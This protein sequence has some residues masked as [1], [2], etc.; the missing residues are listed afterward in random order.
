M[1][2]V[3]MLFLL[4]LLFVTARAGAAV[5]FDAIQH[6][7]GSG[8]NRAA[9]VIQFNDGKGDVAYVWGYRWDGIATGE[10]MLRTVARSSQ[11][12]TPLVQYTGSMGSTLDGVGFSANRSVLDHITYDF[13][14][15]A[16]GGEVSF[17]YFKPNEFM[18]Q[19]DAP[20]YDTPHLVQEAIDNAKVNGVIEHPL[21]A[22]KYGY[23]AYDYDYW[24]PDSE[25]K[26]DPKM[27]WQ[28][29]WYEGYWSYWV[30]SVG[31]DL[32]YS[33]LGM[34]SAQIYDGSINLWNYNP[35]M[36]NYG[37]A[38]DPSSNY[39][40]AMQDYG[41]QMHEAAPVEYDVDFGKI[42]SWI[43]DGEKSAAL[44]FKF[45]D[46]K[47]PDNIVV[48]YRWSGG[49]DDRLG[50]VLKSVQRSNL[51]ADY[52]S[53]PEG[54]EWKEFGIYPY[55]PEIFQLNDRSF[56]SPHSVIVCT[57]VEE[58][59]EPDYSV[60]PEDLTYNLSQSGVGN[61]AVPAGECV[62]YIYDISGKLVK[63]FTA[64]SGNAADM[65]VSVGTPGVYIIKKITDNIITTQKIILK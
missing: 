24:L 15:A 8:S 3:L 56:V 62:C 42:V 7:A 34:S 23:P 64:A 31:Q 50:D 13:E 22:R 41:E 61:A 53:R 60:N 6:W 14:S 33:G 18:G 4:T 30:G 47:T 5:D 65:E 39:D 12:L 2:K 55:E 1:K 11:C 54:G 26:A 38:P 29:G 44:V 28:S 17:D 52:E 46:G 16:I 35:D 27:H 49:W 40:Y 58:G 10:D 21:N 9:L 51:L 45:N 25:A 37:S 36:A 59:Q 48:G 63:T 57:Y 32:S 43:G 19:T 20:G